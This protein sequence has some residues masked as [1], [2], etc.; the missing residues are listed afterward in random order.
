MIPVERFPWREEAF[1]NKEDM[2][3]FLSIGYFH[4]SPGVYN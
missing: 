1:G 3:V 4:L 2:L